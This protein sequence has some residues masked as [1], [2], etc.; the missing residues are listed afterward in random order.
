MLLNCVCTRVKISRA[1]QLQRALSVCH[2]HKNTKQH[3]ELHEKRYKTESKHR[4]SKKNRWKRFQHT[5]E[6]ETLK[7]HSLILVGVA[8]AFFLLSLFVQM[9]MDNKSEHG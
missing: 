2:Q 8:A 5:G 3:T 4:T 6:R 1:P 7:W 9:C